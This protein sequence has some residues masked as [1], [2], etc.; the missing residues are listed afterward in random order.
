MIYLYLSAIFVLLSG[1][2]ICEL[3]AIFIR[4]DYAALSKH[5]AGAAMSNYFAIASRGFVSLYG[6]VVA[7]LIEELTISLY[8]YVICVS[9][10]LALAGSASV[11]LSRKTLKIN[12]G[13]IIIS[14]C[15]IKEFNL[16]IQYEEK[17]LSIN[18]LLIF[19]L[20]IQ[21]AAISLAYAMCMIFSENR[22]LIIS[23]APA[24]SMLGTLAAAV[25]IEP[26]FAEHVDLHPEHGYVVSSIY[27]KARAFS[28]FIWAFIFAAL[29]K[30]QY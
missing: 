13:R 9:C 18:F 4:Y 5:M 26:K 7:Y 27:L 10:A 23:I 25:L 24:L 17:S 12:N 19:L 15:K 14:N 20:G 22:L 21:F 1:H 11:I 16:H 3:L 28:F 30:F 8:G 6:I 2:L 29:I